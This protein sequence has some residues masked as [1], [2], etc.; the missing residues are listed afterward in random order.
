MKIQGYALVGAVVALLAGCGGGGSDDGGSNEPLVGPLNRYAGTY[1]NC[2]HNE[3]STLTITSISVN[4]ISISERTDYSQESNCT[5][6]IVATD[7]M[8][9]HAT[10]TF[11]STSQ[12]LV[13]GYPAPNSV[14]TYTVDRLSLSIPAYTVSLTGPGVRIINGQPC[15]VYTG[16]Q[17]C[18]TGAL[19]YPATANVIGG[20]TFTDVALLTLEATASGYER[21]YA[22]PR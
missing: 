7:S 15:V 20:L 4:S 6:G 2:E 3:R 11:V 13:T 8:S 14:A 5:G 22:Y 17:T 16:G 18:L 12:A 21:G 19:S 10:G 9:E 1:T